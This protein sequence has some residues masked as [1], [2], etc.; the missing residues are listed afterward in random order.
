MKTI[1][2]DAWPETAP[3]GSEDDQ[4][5]RLTADSACPEADSFQRLIRFR[6]ILTLCLKDVYKQVLHSCIVF[7]SPADAALFCFVLHCVISVISDNSPGIRAQKKRLP[8]SH[9]TCGMNNAGYKSRESREVLQVL[10]V[11]RRTG[12]A[13]I[14]CLILR[15][16]WRVCCIRTRLLFRPRSRERLPRRKSKLGD[17]ISEKLTRPVKYGII[18]C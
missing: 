6:T 1:R 9:S 14:H 8:S 4:R 12:L 16:R 13:E 10:H 5:R 15:E 7:F 17:S 11:L 3:Y 18:N 2:V